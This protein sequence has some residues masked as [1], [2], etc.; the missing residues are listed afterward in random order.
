MTRC[1]AVLA[2]LLL[3]LFARPL[4]AFDGIRLTLLGGAEQ[5]AQDGPS[6]PGIL[7]EA[8]D[9]L[10]LFDCGVGSLARLRSARFPLRE[11]TAV[12][13]T[14]LDSTHVG[15]CAEL[16]A[17]W[18]RAGAE[19]PLPL[20]GPEG[21]IQAVQAWVG[22]RGVGGVGGI[23]PHEIGENLVYDS[24]DVRVT[25]IVADYPTRFRAYGY[26]VDRERRAVALL[27]GAGYSENVA[28]G[29][30]GAQVVVSDVAA[31][32]GQEEAAEPG[33]RA[34][35]ATH[36][37]PEDAGRILHGAR[38]YL[39]LYS[40]LQVF[41]VGVEEVVARTR[42]YYRGPLQIAH[43]LMI[44]EIQNEVQIRSAPSDGPRQ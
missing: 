18:V 21:T 9:E 25:A 36:A 1:S 30:R 22:A 43:A 19:P 10:L 28:H 35:L 23:D 32:A 26:R 16:L 29:A 27:A 20:W 7:V 13:L 37:S 4:A 44:V 6:G 12:F 8:G 40:H 5:S 24:D 2:A 33:V 11:L 42:R 17:A 3:S 14:S 34:A 15:G 39:G 31:A 41:G 38:P